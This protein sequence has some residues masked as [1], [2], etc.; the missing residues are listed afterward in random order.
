MTNDQRLIE[1]EIK[2]SHQDVLLEELHGVICRQQET[3]DKLEFSLNKLV[4][5]IQGD[6]AQPESV[7]PPH[8]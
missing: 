8:Y 1:I 2:V 7:K 4:D 3:I 5:R 6:S